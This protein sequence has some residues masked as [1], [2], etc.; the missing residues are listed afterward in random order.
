[1]PTE[2]DQSL[3]HR[4][5]RGFVHDPLIALLGGAGGSAGLFSNAR[6]VAVICQMLLQ[7]GEYAGIQYFNPGTVKMFTSSDFSPEDNRRGGGFDKPPADTCQPSPTAPSASL[8]SFGHSGFTGTYCW[9]DPEYQLVYVFLSNRVYPSAENKLLIQ[10]GI[11]TR[12]QEYLYQ[13]DRENQAVAR[14]QPRKSPWK[15]D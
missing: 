15:E 1:M 10:S 7:G 4:Q 12:I 9:V 8:S 11:R 14:E 5:I 2:N 3:R 6:D 13:A